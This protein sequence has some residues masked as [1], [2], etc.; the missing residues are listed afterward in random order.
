[1]EVLHKRHELE[2]LVKNNLLHF[3]LWSNVQVQNEYIPWK[4]M[5]LRLLTGKPSQKLSND[6]ENLGTDGTLMTEYILPINMSQYKTEF[7]TIQCLDMIFEKLCPEYV[8]RLVLAIVSDDG[9]TVFYFAY[10]G[11][12]KPKRN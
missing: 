10:K 7:I 3:Q 1:M 6:D 5:E 11:I 9:T 12:H 8:K 2:E 4:G